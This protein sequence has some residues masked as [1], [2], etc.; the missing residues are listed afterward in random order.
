MSKIKFMVDSTSD[1]P[2]EIAER[3]H[4]SVVG[5]SITF[6]DGTYTDW[7]DLSGKAFYDKLRAS[8]SAVTTS[9]P[10][11]ALIADE[12]KSILEEGYEEIIF[13][14]ISSKGSGTFNC[15]NLAK[16]SV[17]EEYP[18]ATIHIVDS[19]SY[20]YFITLAML[21]GIQLYQEGKNG[22]EI[23]RGSVEYLNRL[24]VVF[25]VD[26]LTYLER[27][28]RINKATMILG[29]MLNIKPVLSVRNGIIDTVDKF[30]GSKNSIRKLVEK[31]KSFG[32]DPQ[33]PD[34]SIVHSDALDK[35][36]ELLSVIREEAPGA[37][38]VL[39]GMLGGVIGAH[40]GP[41]VVALFFEKQ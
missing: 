19:M 41:G 31:A 9:Q 5:L 24:D 12:M 40:T 17:L 33:N 26:T 35:A 38:P 39:F 28:G 22:D 20:S 16:E 36:N 18:Q 8:K 34:F 13:Y 21:R 37:N 25:L 30:R 7:Y 32:Y 6:E 11:V 10:P 4:V 29:N 15:A 1:I 14:T 3:Y 23:V 2:K 27:G